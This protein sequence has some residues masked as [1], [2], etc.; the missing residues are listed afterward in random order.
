MNR[1]KIK[2]PYAFMEECEKQYSAM[3]LDMHEPSKS[4]GK[5]IEWRGHHWVCVGAASQYLRLLGVELRMC[6]PEEEYQGKPNNP[7]VSGHHYYTGGRFTCK[8]RTWVMTDKEITLI[9]YTQ[10]E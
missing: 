8:G 2:A 6:V 3:T 7:E 1:M 9:P 4:K 10:K 5:V